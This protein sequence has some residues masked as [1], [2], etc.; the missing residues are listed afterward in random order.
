MKKVLIIYYT[1][2]GQLK[3]ILDSLLQPLLHHSGIQISYLEI[4]P[5]VPFPFPWTLREFL[6][7]FPE[8][9]GQAPVR[10]LP[11]EIDASAP[12]DL[13]L[14]AFQPWYLSPSPPI[15]SL[16]NSPA[17]ENIFNGANVLTV[18]GARNMWQEAHSDVREKV[19]KAG[20]RLCGN[21]ALV[22][23]APNLVSVVTIVYW[24]FTGKKDRFLGLFPKPGVSEADI[25]AAKRFGTVLA[26]PLLENRLESLG[27]TLDSLGAAEIPPSLSRLEKRAKKVFTLWS[28]LIIRAPK[29]RG[30]LLYL[31]LAELLFALA[32]ISPIF[33]FLDVL[34]K[35]FRKKSGGRG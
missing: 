20:G 18:I 31:F 35:P 27:M 13:I 14:L 19:E 25:A 10:L 22:D 26:P 21:I 32:F 12:Y 34:M 8:S 24:L 15:S 28:K 9:V 33:S 7:V 17:A 23:R 5:E 4:V 2:T 3:S 29:I 11:L 1:Q 30:L 16:L 6:E